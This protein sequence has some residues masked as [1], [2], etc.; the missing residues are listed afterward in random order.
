[1][2]K[3]ITAGLLIGAGAALVW[4]FR[5]KFLGTTFIRQI[6]LT[7]KD[8]RCGIAEEPARVE[9]SKKRGDMLL[10]EISSPQGSGCE[11][12]RTV[13]IG[14]WRLNH[15]PTNEPPVT[16]PEG[17]CRQVTHGNPPMHIRAHINSRA[18]FGEYKYDIL[19]DDVV[20]LDPIVKLTP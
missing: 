11:G 17:L 14:N 1:M 19:V 6:A 12:Q 20:V 8:G 15:L 18:A 13:C 5:G 10:W 16:N 7:L 3:K 2:N 9:L 4:F